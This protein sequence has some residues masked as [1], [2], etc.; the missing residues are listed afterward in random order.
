M[1]E[2]KTLVLVNPA[3][4][5]GKWQRQRRTLLEA[6]GPLGSVKM[7]TSNSP[8]ELTQSAHRAVE[9]G[10]DLVVA[11]GGDGTVHSVLQALVGSPT[12]LGI[13][14]MGRG[15]DIAHNLRIPKNP[16]AACRV[17]TSGQTKS[18]DVGS[19]G[20]RFF[21]GVAGVGL[22]SVVNRY[23]NDHAGHWPGA[24]VYPISVLRCLP[25]FSAPMVCLKYS[26]G[27]YRGRMTLIAICN[28]ACYGGGMR[29]APAARPDDG[30]LDMCLI[31][32]LSRWRLLT[33][34][35]KVY[36]GW[37]IRSRFTEYLRTEFVEI[38][39][40]QELDLYADGEYL[41]KTPARVSILP[42]AL[43]VVVPGETP[44]FFCA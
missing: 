22:D 23:A 4:G 8:S 7:V 42:Q 35:P 36:F 32:N 28:L 19:V 2:R 3:S 34:F 31:K 37:H 17:L 9:E 25:R 13:V 27:C 1:K 11:C 33:A 5:A 12:A 29:I 39:S 41:Q 16:K 20:N 44:R 10:A 38:E 24:L 40:E 18:V 15:N 26:E 14:P 43:R 21:L 30:R 6:L